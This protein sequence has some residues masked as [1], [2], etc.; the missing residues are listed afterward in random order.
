[1]YAN[2]S[3]TV[4]CDPTGY[5]AATAGGDFTLEGQMGICAIIQTL[6]CCQ[7]MLSPHFG[8]TIA[9]LAPTDYYDDS[10]NKIKEILYSNA[11]KPDENT[12]QVTVL[13]HNRRLSGL[14]HSRKW[15]VT[16]FPH[17]RY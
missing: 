10:Y 2:A 12:G 8:N 3:P 1:M 13:C 17:N 15:H 6:A 5:Y 16:I 14:R 7:V 4:Y 11:D 9:T